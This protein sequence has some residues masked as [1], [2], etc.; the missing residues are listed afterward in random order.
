MTYPQPIMVS[1]LIISDFRNYPPE[2]PEDTS[3]KIKNNTNALKSL[4][5][6]N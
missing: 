1:Q 2:K 5:G 4:G 3:G 6:S